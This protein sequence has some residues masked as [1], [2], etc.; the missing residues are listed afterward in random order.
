MVRERDGCLQREAASEEAA[1]EQAAE[2]ER[3]LGE[4]QAAQ[5]AKAEAAQAAAR[6]LAAAEEDCLKRVEDAKRVEAERLAATVDDCEKQ[7]QEALAAN[8]VLEAK[9][10]E[11]INGKKQREHHANL[12]KAIM[13]NRRRKEPGTSDKKYPKLEG[14]FQN[15]KKKYP[16][17]PDDPA[18]YME[19]LGELEKILRENEVPYMSSPPSSISSSGSS[20]LSP[21]SAKPR[22]ASSRLRISEP[23]PSIN[24]YP[25]EIYGAPVPGRPTSRSGRGRGRGRGGGRGG[26]SDHK[27]GT[28]NKIS[29]KKKIHKGGRNNKKTLKKKVKLNKY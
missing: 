7:L 11:L 20:G 10:E 12:H 19:Y 8:A 29:S 9:L 13:D 1:T 21:A 14:Q 5:T 15:F 28:I 24:G 4:L 6:E 2:I 22:P 16:T 27:G 17:Q 23:T 3:L 26:G 25:G 18:I